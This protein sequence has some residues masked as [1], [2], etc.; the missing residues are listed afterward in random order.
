MFVVIIIIDYYY[1]FTVEE[2]EYRI[3]SIEIGEGGKGE[4]SCPKYD[5]VST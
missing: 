3:Y 4:K 2:I 1:Y 5:K